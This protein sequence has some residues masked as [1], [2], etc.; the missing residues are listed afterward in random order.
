MYRQ[1][2]QTMALSGTVFIFYFKYVISEFLLF[3]NK[4][5]L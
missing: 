5:V 3:K 1:D 4:I 2:T